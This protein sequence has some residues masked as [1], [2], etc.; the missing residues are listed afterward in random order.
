[1]NLN[2]NVVRQAGITPKLFAALVW[3]EVYACVLLAGV[4]GTAAV[5]H[6]AVKS[7]SQCT[8]IRFND[9]IIIALVFKRI[10]TTAAAAAPTEAEALQTSSVFK[11]HMNGNTCD[12][13]HF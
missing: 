8:I 5:V 13:I 4:G 3:N 11:W 7:L 10:T 1:M 9:V 12:E 2:V 6:V